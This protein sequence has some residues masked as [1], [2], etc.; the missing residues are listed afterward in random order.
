VT[1][2]EPDDANQM[3]SDQEATEQCERTASHL[4]QKTVHDLRNELA[5]LRGALNLIE[6]NP[7]DRDV[8]AKLHLGARASIKQIAAIIDTLAKSVRKEELTAESREE[9]VSSRPAASNRPI[10]VTSASLRSATRLHQ[11]ILVADDNIDSNNTLATILRLDGHEVVSVYDGD[12]ALSVA[13]DAHP[14]VLLLDISMP[15]KD[16]CAVAREIRTRQWAGECRLIAI[17]GRDQ[18]ED[19]QRIKEAGFSVHL[20]KPVDFDAL[21]SLLNS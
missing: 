18:P 21:S 12:E 9:E 14:D 2:T 17:S 16:G 3:L 6:R 19:I 20:T 10:A 11:R 7:A 1:T 15:G 4:I 13:E 5:S 8:A